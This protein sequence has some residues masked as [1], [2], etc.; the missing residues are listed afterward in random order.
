MTEQGTLFDW[1]HDAATG[2]VEP[3][4]P[5]IRDSETSKAAACAVRH[6]ADSMV[7]QVLDVF[8]NAG[9]PGMTDNELIDH[10]E[11]CGWSRNT[12]RARRVQLANEGR[13]EKCGERGGCA[14]WRAR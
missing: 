14:V 2:R 9:S 4:V 11:G 7:E 5:F 13:I 8:R 1:A 10:F 6:R 12:P 3:S